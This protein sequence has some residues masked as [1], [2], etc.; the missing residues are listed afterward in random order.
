MLDSRTGNTES[1]LEGDRE[2]IQT[3]LN[4][5]V[6][7][8]YQ[9]TDAAAGVYIQDNQIIITICGEKPNL[10]NFWS[11]RF[12]SSWRIHFTSPVAVISGEIK[13]SFGIVRLYS[14]YLGPDITI[15]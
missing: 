15:A 4:S 3:S 13:V 1:P 9:T 11:G 10:R 12:H 7:L 5:Y 6:A 8:K 2:A 14:L